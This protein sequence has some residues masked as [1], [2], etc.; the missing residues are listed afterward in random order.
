MASFV[1]KVT[2]KAAKNEII[3]WEG[4]LLK[5]RLTAAPEK[6]KANEAL[7]TLLSKKLKIAKSRIHILKG[8][9]S[10]QKLVEIEGETLSSLQEKVN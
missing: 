6:G 10:R 9:T 3:G 7:I 5:V 4:E 1:V 8:E 2:P